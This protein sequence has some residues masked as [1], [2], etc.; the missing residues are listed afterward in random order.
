MKES[1]REIPVADRIQLVQELW[2]SIAVD[3]SSLAITEEQKVLLDKRLQAYSIDRNI[4]APAF[5]V[6]EALRREL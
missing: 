2:D 5:G 1:L 4:G 6:L 3:Q